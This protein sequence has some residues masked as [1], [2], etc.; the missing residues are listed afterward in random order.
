[1]SDDAAM[2]SS[3]ESRVRAFEAELQKATER[4][5]LAKKAVKDAKALA[6]AARKDKRAARRALIAAQEEHSVALLDAEKE[7]KNSSAEE[8]PRESKA[9]H[10][11]SAKSSPRHS[12]H[13]VRIA[14]SPEV[15]P[16]PSAA[17]KRA[18]RAKPMKHS[19]NDAPAD[20]PRNAT[21]PLVESL[22]ESSAESGGQPESTE[23]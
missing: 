12:S 17:K 23:E 5:R 1:M 22:A 13:K 6:K 15:N 7:S 11:K 19:V 16:P 18:A 3:V 9:R 4:S 14:D 21:A 20:E 8:K 10:G 2:T